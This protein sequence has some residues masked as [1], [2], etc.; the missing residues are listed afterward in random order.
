M[1]LLI[2]PVVLF[3]IMDSQPAVTKAQLLAAKRTGTR[4]WQV[5]TG[6]G[7]MK[8]LPFTEIQDEEYSTYLRTA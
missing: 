8:M 6:A 1:A 5:E 7:A 3:A 2:G 4:N